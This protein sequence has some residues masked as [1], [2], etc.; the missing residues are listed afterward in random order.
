MKMDSCANSWKC[1]SAFL[2]FSKRKTKTNTFCAKWM[3]APIL[4]CIWSKKIGKAPCKFHGPIRS[5]ASTIGRLSKPLNGKP[6]MAKC[7]RVCSTNPKTTTLAKNTRCCFITT[8]STQTTCTTTK[9]LS[10]RQVS[11]TRQ[12]T[13]AVVIW[14]SSQTSVTSQVNPPKAPTTAS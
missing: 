1:H 11:S 4:I 3:C 7:S 6:T 8:N 13:R 5:K 2:A 9:R 12:N 10:P 14:C